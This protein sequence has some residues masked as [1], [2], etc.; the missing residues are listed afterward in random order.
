MSDMKKSSNIGIGTR[1]SPSPSSPCA[2]CK[3]L[4]RR[5][6]PNCIFAPYFPSNHVQ[7]FINVHKIFGASNVGKLLRDIPPQLREDAANSLAYEAD[8]RVRDPVYGCV[9]DITLLQWKMAHLQHDLMSVRT[10]LARYTAANPD[11]SFPLL[12]L[13]SPSSSSSTSILPDLFSGYPAAADVDAVADQLFSPVLA[14]ESMD[15]LP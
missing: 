5:C 8:A 12:P 7:R 10:R 9:G 11:H 15:H 6:M 14:S 13:S 4:K 3:F 1:L 2:A